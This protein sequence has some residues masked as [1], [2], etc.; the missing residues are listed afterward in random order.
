MFVVDSKKPHLY[1]TYR[2]QKKRKAQLQ[3]EPLC[4]MC[5]KRGITT[6]ANIADHIEPHKGDEAKFWGNALQSLC[7]PCHDSDKQ[8]QERGSKPKARIGT[9]GWPID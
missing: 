7:K 8:R 5:F 2:W 3:A 9:D 1:G 4:A 6:V